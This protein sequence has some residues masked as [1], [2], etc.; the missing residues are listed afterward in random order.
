MKSQYEVDLRL[1]QVPTELSEATNGKAEC[2]VFNFTRN[3]AGGLK[4]AID[5]LIA[6][7]VPHGLDADTVKGTIAR[8]KSDSFEESLPFFESKLLHRVETPVTTDSPTRSAFNGDETNG[9]TSNSFFSKIRKPGSMSSFTSF[10]DRRKTAGSNSPGSVFKHASS[11]A[12]KASL[13]SIESQSSYRNPWNDSSLQINEE[14]H[15]YPNNQSSTSLHHSNGWSAT[16]P[17]PPRSSE[18]G[19]S[20]F[21]F[22]ASISAIPGDATPRYDQRAIGENGRPSTSHSISGYPGPIGPPR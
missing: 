22:G 14:G 20:K 10:I 12:S 13:I 11:N 6:R 15:A 2:L 7:L 17:H 8:P 21:P 19:H 4:D 9:E 5:F 18:N 16:H 1:G 3:A